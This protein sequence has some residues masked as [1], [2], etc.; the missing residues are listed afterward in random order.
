MPRI[1]SDDTY[2][3]ALLAAPR[4][5]MDRV[6]AF[7]DH[8][9]GLICKDPRYL[10]I[11]MDDHLV[12]RGDGVFETLKFTAGRIYQLDAHVERLFHSATTIAI[13][14][15]CSRQD[16]RQLLIELAA[17]S[18]LENGLLA[19]YV[20]RGPGGFTA[21]FREC[22]QPSLYAVAR[23][24]P[25][26]S[27]ALWENGVTAYTTG[28]PAK[29]CYL[30]RIKTVDYLPNVLMKR[31]AVLKGYDY[32]LCFDEQGFLAEGATENVCL[33]NSSGELIVPELRNALPGTTLLR[34]L[35]LIRPELPIEHRLVKEDELYQAREL[36]LLGTSLDAVSV[37]RFNDRPIHDVRPGPVSQRL[38]QLLLEDHRRTGTP[39]A[40][41]HPAS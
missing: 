35:D 13:H 19:V 21:D 9:V 38:R 5:G 30:S 27:E 39:I 1:V 26:Y 6:R 16:V 14:P 28:F 7:Y 18:E 15:P 24:A 41:A 34:G 22:P 33:V 29:Q 2:Q 3:K 17:A 23:V 8:R 10:L 20:G 32:P 12:H 36:I 40:D 37:V 25:Q 31:E 4:P 11:P